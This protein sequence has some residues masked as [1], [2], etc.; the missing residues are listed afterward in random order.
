MSTEFDTLSPAVQRDIIELQDKIDRFKNGEIPEERF[1]AFRLTRG[2]YGQRQQGVQMFRIKLP[3]GK[4]SPAQ[5]RTMADLAE[6]FGHGNLHLTTRQNIQLH[7]V[8]VANAPRIWE[9]LESVGV[10]AREACGNTVRNITASPYAGIDP[11][12]PFDVSPYAQAVFEYFLRNPICQDMGRKIKMAFSSS[13]KDSAFTYIHDFGFIPKVIEIQGEEK[14]GFRVV[15]GGGL[16]AQAFVAETAYEFLE[17]EKL[18]PF[19]EAG[20]RVFDRYGERERRNKARLKFLIDPK[21]GL[22]LEK[23]LQLVEEERQA[24]PNQVIW[25]DRETVPNEI[26]EATTTEG[27][28]QSSP[29]FE[30]WLKANVI[31]Q[32]QAGFY[33][34]KIKVPLGNLDVAKA[35]K[36]ADLVEKWASKDARLT[37]NQGVLLKFLRQEELLGL[38]HDLQALELGNSGFESLGDIIACPGTDTCNLAVTNSTDLTTELESLIQNE[39]PHLI[40]EANI[41]IK[42]SGC[43]NSCGQ[44]MI[45][46][47]GFHGSSIKYQGKVSPAQQVVLGG[48]V[49]PEGKGFIAEKVIK[50]PTKR[51][52]DTVRNLL[53][54]YEANAT[55]EEYFNQYFQRQGKMYFY[56]LLKPLADLSTLDEEG[57]QDWGREVSFIPEIGVGECAGVV[58]DLVSTIVG[59][60]QEK[61]TWGREALHESKWAGAIYHA[62][63]AMV[64]GAK[65]LLLHDEIQCNTHNQIIN[66]FQE[67]LIAEGKFSSISDFPETVLQINKNEPSEDF[68]NTYVATAEAF[69]AEVLNYRQVQQEEK[70]VISNFYKA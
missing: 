37:I 11:N 10:T 68:A 61:A 24:L 36:F 26:P 9:L 38:F 50:V 3:Y 16:G 59:D 43:M 12:E 5:I 2:V 57:F 28:L 63:S 60:A 54:D 4:I 53:L 29:A 40:D 44:H 67:K 39:F 22:G 21:K 31:E 47:I 52:P 18:I 25:V 34:A 14:R 64:I 20:L 19:I 66:T 46:N 15:V 41:Q 58:L 8:D 27:N 17:E 7:Y 48:G 49:D 35:R 1:K 30:Q 70:L 45:A 62:Y 55:E 13:E 65:A 23:F 56:E 6:E 51:V 69:I 33:A 32:K 42:I